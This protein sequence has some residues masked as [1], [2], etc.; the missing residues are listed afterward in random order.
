MLGAPASGAGP[1]GLALGLVT[2]M[3]SAAAPD[4]MSDGRPPPAGP[5]ARA[6]GGRWRNVGAVADATASGP[7]GGGL[8]PVRRLAAAVAVALALAAGAL[9]LARAL[10]DPVG[11]GAADVARPVA[12]EVAVPNAAL[13]PAGGLPPLAL[14]LGEPLPPEIRGLPPAEQVAALQSSAQGEA[15]SPGALVQLGALL[16]GLGQAA[17]AEAAYRAAL[18]RDPDNTPA[19]VGLAMVEGAEDPEG[20]ARAAR[21]LRTLSRERPESQL[22][23]FNEGWLAVY[24]GDAAVARRAWTR[25]VALDARSRLGE[26]AATFLAALERGPGASAG[27]A[28]P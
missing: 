12:G 24:R 15:R 11:S 2:E 10:D 16:Q 14:V 3:P 26:A 22:V 27:P 19:I 25:A 8:P 17:P 5:S 20:L 9:G 18:R 21:I 23:A 7:R 13:T 4:G 28:E 1:A 6:G